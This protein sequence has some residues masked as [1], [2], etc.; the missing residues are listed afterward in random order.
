MSG[1]NLAC[2][3][4]LAAILGGVLFAAA[5]V[6]QLTCASAAAPSSQALIVCVALSLL[7]FPLLRI[8][9]VLFFAAGLTGLY[10]LLGSRR[11]P[12]G[13]SGLMLAYLSV[14]AS[15]SSI[16]LSV[17]L[18]YRAATNPDPGFDP[19][20]VASA[21]GL[22]QV[23]LLGGSVLLIGVAVFR[24]RSLERWSTLP[25]VLCLLI[26]TVALFPVL[27]S[28]FD[29]ALAP[30]RTVH[31]LLAILQGLCWVLLGGV[32]WTYASR[33]EARAPQ[34]TPASNL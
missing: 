25:L 6:L 24:A 14:L 16:A 21:A 9:S 5:E 27:A 28:Y 10:A 22:T 11:S 15:V 7:L 31:R 12:I 13:L 4:G 18:S 3:G 33:G 2:P 20:S 1:S 23:L 32:L 17:Y 30:W 29:L 19:T 26:V 34:S 8:F